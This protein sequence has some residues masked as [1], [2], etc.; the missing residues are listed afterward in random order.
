MY[1]C[2]YL[3]LIRKASFKSNTGWNKSRDLAAMVN[4]KLQNASLMG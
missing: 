1:S 3:I 2:V 4:L